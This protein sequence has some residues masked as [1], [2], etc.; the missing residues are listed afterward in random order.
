MISMKNRIHSLLQG[1]YLLKKKVNKEYLLEIE[2][3]IECEAH[4]ELFLTGIKARRNVYKCL[5]KRKF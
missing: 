4:R 5:V 1:G 2:N 3:F